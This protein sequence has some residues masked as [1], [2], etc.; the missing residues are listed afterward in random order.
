MVLIDHWTGVVTHKTWCLCL[1]DSLRMYFNLV[2]LCRAITAPNDFN[3]L[4]S[5]FALPHRMSVNTFGRMSS[6]H[7]PSVAPP[8]VCM[9]GCSTW[10]TARTHTC[11]VA[12]DLSLTH[13]LT[14][15]CCINYLVWYQRKVFFRLWGCIYTSASDFNMWFSKCVCL[16]VCIFLC[17]SRGCLLLPVWHDADT[18]NKNKCRFVKADCFH[19]TYC[20]CV[21]VHACAR[22]CIPPMVTK[23]AGVALGD[24]T[25]DTFWG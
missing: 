6:S 10:I 8:P 1:N 12:G 21:C 25:S 5:I 18:L 2:Y 15:L 16:S 11:C 24:I 14:H 17:V 3:S 19:P 23:E 9:S 22:F 4:P 7:P 13:S 20:A